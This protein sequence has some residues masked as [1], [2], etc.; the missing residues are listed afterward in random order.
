MSVAPP[1]FSRRFFADFIACLLRSHSL[2]EGGPQTSKDPSALS[3]KNPV[4]MDSEEPPRTPLVDRGGL[5]SGF[6]STGV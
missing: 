1:E 5:L 4:P 3:L 2:S 6:G